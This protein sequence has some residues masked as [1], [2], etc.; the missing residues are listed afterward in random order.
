[1]IKL[2][3]DKSGWLAGSGYAGDVKDRNEELDE[4]NR[5]AWIEVKQKKC[6]VVSMYSTTCTSI[7]GIE[8]LLRNDPEG[9]PRSSG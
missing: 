8:D 5:R 9:R 1:M 4:L 3:G 7:Y 6:Q 2:V